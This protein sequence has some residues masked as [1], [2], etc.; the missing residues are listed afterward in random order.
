MLI[1]FSI[2]KLRRNFFSIMETNQEFYVKY[3]DNIA[4]IETTFFNSNLKREVPLADVG[5]LIKACRD[6]QT[7]AQLGLPKIPGPLTLHL[8]G[9]V[10]RQSVNETDAAKLEDD[11][12]EEGDSFT[13]D[14]PLTALG[15]LGSRSKKPL[16]LRCKIQVE[17]IGTFF[18]M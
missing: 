11:H 9:G 10:D 18:L 16:V 13:G 15:T 17:Q 8:P 7:T 14:C 3:L 5:D 4:P 1:E 12:F 2:S 6:E